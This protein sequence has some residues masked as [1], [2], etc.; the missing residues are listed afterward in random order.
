M[1]YGYR[2]FLSCNIL[3]GELNKNVYEFTID[4]YHNIHELTRHNVGMDDWA[5]KSQRHRLNL[6]MSYIFGLNVR[7]NL[8]GV[9]NH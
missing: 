2:L 6:A 7:V 1:L 4:C 9:F 8:L 3:I 5:H